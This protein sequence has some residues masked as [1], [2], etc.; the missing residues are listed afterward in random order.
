[1][2]KII[3]GKY[4][5]RNIGTLPNRLTRPTSSKVRGAVLNAI[6][7]FFEKGSC[8]DLFAGSG[9]FGIEMLSRGYDKCVFVDKNYQA[10]QIIKQNTAMCDETIEILKVDY[11]SALSKLQDQQFDCIF[12]DPPY[13]L[14][15]YEE[16]LQYIDEHQMLLKDG[17]VICESDVQVEMPIQVGNFIC[18]NKRVYGMSQITY[19]E[20]G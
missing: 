9:A 17:K 10:I 5:S 4:G 2:I 14:N 16:V 11:K 20:R 3:A 12:L 1:M 15:I 18:T 19:Y 7:P 6:G 8:L 13:R